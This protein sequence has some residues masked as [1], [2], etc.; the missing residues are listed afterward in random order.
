MCDDSGLGDAPGD[1]TRFLM[2]SI[3]SKNVAQRSPAE[4]KPHQQE[5]LKWFLEVAPSLAAPYEAAVIMINDGIIPA[6]IHLICHIVRDIY[7]ELPAILDGNYSRLHGGA[8]YPAAIDKIAIA[9]ESYFVESFD[10]SADKENPD[11]SNMISISMHS[12]RQVYAL[13]QQH[14]TIKNQASSGRVLA[15]ALYR[16]YATAGSMPS[17]R[18]I[19]TFDKARVWF[20]RRAH[21]VRDPNKLPTDEGL[22]DNFEAFERTLHSLIAPH[23]TIKGELDDILQEANS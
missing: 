11:S 8:V 18:V 12:I 13:V 7:N 17:D 6:R 23:F 21:L 4:W 15:E 1:G 3:P 2:D 9:F 16:Q 19:R 14:E 20:T 22:R 10:P 5:L